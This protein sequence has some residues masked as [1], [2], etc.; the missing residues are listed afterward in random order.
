M[1]H[2]HHRR[3]EPEVVRTARWILAGIFLLLCV[4]DAVCYNYSSNPLVSDPVVRGHVIVS[5]LWT[6][7]FLI[8]LWMRRVWARYVLILFLGYIALST[9]VLA[10][11]MIFSPDILVRPL[12]AIAGCFTA[13][14]SGVMILIFSR[15]IGRLANRT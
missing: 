12:M 6:T 1:S 2:R 10:S 13:Y 5:L 4:A 9:C 7:V 3:H 14:F 11:M 15:D 8:P